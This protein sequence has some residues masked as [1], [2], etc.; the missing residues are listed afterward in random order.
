MRD[1]E[2]VCVGTKLLA[3]REVGERRT[4]RQ[5]CRTNRHFKSGQTVC[6]VRVYV[7]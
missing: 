4:D 2:V 3:A 7:T 1:A 5:S 6:R